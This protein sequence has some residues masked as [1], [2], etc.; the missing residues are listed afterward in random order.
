MQKPLKPSTLPQSTHRLLQMRPLLVAEQRQ[1]FA[2]EGDT[3]R[4]TSAG[5]GM[6]RLCCPGIGCFQLFSFSCTSVGEELH[7]ARVS[8][9]VTIQKTVPPQSGEQSRLENCASARTEHYPE[10]YVWDD[11][12]YQ[13]IS[14]ATDNSRT[15]WDSHRFLA[16][17]FCIYGS[18]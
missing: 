8:T 6:F 1:G 16:L 17:Q 11:L 15:I 14:V 3:L 10:V 7:E 18:V 9:S 4:E 5:A 13:F 2:V 12:G